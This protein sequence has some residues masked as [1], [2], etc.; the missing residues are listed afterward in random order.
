MCCRWPQRPSD[1]RQ[2]HRH[3]KDDGP[4]DEE[5]VDTAEEDWCIDKG[6][7]DIRRRY[8]WDWRATPARIGKYYLHTWRKTWADDRDA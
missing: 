6:N 5:E 3:Q 2:N 8:Y 7:W 4:N 1:Q